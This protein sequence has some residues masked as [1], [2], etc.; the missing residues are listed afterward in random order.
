MVVFLSQAK[1]G[2]KEE[3]GLERGSESMKAKVEEFERKASVKREVFLSRD[4]SGGCQGLGGGM[5]NWFSMDVK[6]QLG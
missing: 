2:G 6:F 4:H 5:G 3:E 1:K